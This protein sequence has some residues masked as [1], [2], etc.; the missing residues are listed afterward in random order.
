MLK[1]AVGLRVPLTIAAF[2]PLLWSE[3]QRPE[4]A[5]GRTRN[6][7]LRRRQAF[8][9]NKRLADAKSKQAF[10]AA[11]QRINPAGPQ[12]KVELLSQWGDRVQV[13]IDHKRY[14]ALRLE[15]GNEVFLSPKEKRVFI[16][17]I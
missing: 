13:E 7:T 8:L 5:T 15:K 14:Q 6:R 2:L 17:Q 1:S 10:R 16:Y 12:V 3:A 4:G 11:V 9:A